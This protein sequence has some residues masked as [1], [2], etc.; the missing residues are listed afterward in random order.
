M[1]KLTI[2]GRQSIPP[3]PAA[4]LPRSRKPP[5]GEG[6]VWRG[7]TL[8]LS[9]GVPAE[10]RA[11]RR[12]SLTV[13]HARHE[14][15]LAPPRPCRPGRRL[16]CSGVFAKAASVAIPCLRSVISCRSAH[17]MTGAGLRSVISCRGA[18]GMTGAGLRSAMSCRSAHGM[19]GAGQNRLRSLPRRLSASGAGGAAF[20][21]SSAACT[22]PGRLNVLAK[23]EAG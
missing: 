18:Q 17:G 8:R 15:R 14:A 7:L 3:P 13:R 16:R 11:G 2:R 19:T 21:A 9:K 12:R 20:A 22:M 5:R 10:G 4:R 23:V 1:A 6:G